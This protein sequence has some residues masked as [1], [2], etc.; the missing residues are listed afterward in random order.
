MSWLFTNWRN[1][2]LHKQE[3]SSFSNLSMV[4]IRI[5]IIK[6]HTSQANSY[7]RKSKLLHLLDSSPRELQEPIL[8]YVCSTLAHLFKCNLN[9]LIDVMLWEFKITLYFKWPDTIE[10]SD[11]CVVPIA[12][13]LTPRQTRNIFTLGLNRVAIAFCFNPLDFYVIGSIIV[14]T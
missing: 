5:W 3:K 4:K 2:L 10:R 7:S 9:A 8:V 14:N 11:N 6:Q 13:K 12:S 1:Q